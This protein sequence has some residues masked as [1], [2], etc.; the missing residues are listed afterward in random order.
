[1]CERQ[2]IYHRRWMMGEHTLEIGERP[3]IMGILNI[4][5]DSFSDGGDHI[6]V[7]TAVAHARHM[8]AEGADIIDVGGESTRPGA[9][10]VTEEEEMT[11]VLPV[12]RALAEQIDVPISID[13]YK[14]KVG[15][16]ALEAGAH[17]IND[18]WGFQ[19]DPDLARVA[20]EMGAPVILMHN[21]EGTDYPEGIFQAIEH[22]F[23][24]SIRIAKEAGVAEGLIAL[25]PGIGFGKTPEQN[26]YVMKHLDR[27]KSMGYPI[28][29]GTSR[30]S[31]IGK[32]LDVPPKERVNGTVATSV[33][34]YMAGAQI[35][36]V[37]DVR[38]NREALAVTR[39][40]LE[41][42]ITWTE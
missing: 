8:V 12:I 3:L 32:V 27:F 41:S 18:I 10:Y 39:A 13:T 17:I 38:E 16:A 40:I 19:Q 29:L 33:M 36:R 31:M 6:A 22:F 14:A 5:P 7:E 37:H 42:E 28:L 34:G 4:T 2:T 1:M 35:F 9:E 26:L 11:R 23:E 30:K 21:Q 15:R 24:K 25:D 20:A